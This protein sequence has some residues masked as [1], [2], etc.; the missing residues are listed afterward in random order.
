MGH[1]QTSGWGG[2]EITSVLLIFCFSYQLLGRELVLRALQTRLGVPVR[3]AMAV[4]KHH[5]QKKLKEEGVYRL[6]LPH[7]CSPS[8]EVRT[9]A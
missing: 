2:G 1:G 8:R 4:M 3:V 7:H 9:G 6:T 5:D